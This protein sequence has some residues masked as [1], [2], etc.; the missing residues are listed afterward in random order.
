MLQVHLK[1]DY[2]LAQIA[3]HH[4][5]VLDLLFSPRFI[6]CEAQHY[7]AIGVAK[8]SIVGYSNK[9]RVWHVDP[10]RKILHM[11]IF[12]ISVIKE[13]VRRRFITIIIIIESLIPFKKSFLIKIYYH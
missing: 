9:V 6:M 13:K 10:W 2:L 11:L 7:M 1:V 5:I 3:N 8:S 12:L 4:L